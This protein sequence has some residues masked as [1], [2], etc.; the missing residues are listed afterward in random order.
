M[1]LG[2]EATLLIQFGDE[3]SGGGTPLPEASLIRPM[4]LRMP[5]IAASAIQIVRSLRIVRPGKTDAAKGD[6]RSPDAMD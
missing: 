1:V 3:L 5:T 6:Q 4:S 2:L